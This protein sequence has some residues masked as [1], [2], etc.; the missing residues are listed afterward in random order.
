MQW[1]DTLKRRAR[2]LIGS[3][4][5]LQQTRKSLLG[6]ENA[7]YYLSLGDFSKMHLL[8]GLLGDGAQ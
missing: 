5:S 8:R 2:H 3:G 4:S 7:L 6:R 1:L